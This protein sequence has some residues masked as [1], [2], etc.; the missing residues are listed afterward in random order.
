[1]CFICGYC[2]LQVK[3]LCAELAVDYV[4]GMNG[5]GLMGLVGLRD[6]ALEKE[7]PRN[8]VDC[9]GSARCL[10]MLEDP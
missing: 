8:C 1:M 3:E 2:L 7:L 6:L 5:Y 9:K 4:L 10:K